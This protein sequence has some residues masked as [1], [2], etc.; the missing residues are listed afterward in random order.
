MSLAD[1][2][3]YIG[4][5]LALIGAGFG[6]SRAYDQYLGKPKTQK[7]SLAEPRELLRRVNI[8]FAK[9]ELESIDIIGYSVHSIYDPLHPLIDFAIRKG[10]QVRF[11]MLDPGSSALR[12][13]VSLEHGVTNL[14]AASF[15]ARSQRS[16]KKTA[17]RIE[18]N[19]ETLKY[20]ANLSEVHC[21]IRVYDAM[22]VYRA[23]LTNVGSTASS[24]LD[25]LQK[26]SRDFRMTD[27]AKK[28]E[29]NEMEER[30]ARNWFDYVWRYRSRPFKT[31][32]IL[33]DLYD[34]LIRINSQKRSDHE[35]WMSEQIGIDIH[36]FKTTWESTTKAS[37]TGDIGSTNNRFEVILE[38]CGKKREPEL[39]ARLAAAEHAFLMKNATLAPIPTR[40]LQ[41][42]RARGYKIGLV[43][44]CSPSVA[45]AISGTPLMSL[46]DSQIFSFSVASVKPESDIYE[47]ALNSIDCA[48][49]NCIF[50]GD[51]NNS[52]LEGASRVGLR[53]IRCT[54][55]VD[56]GVGGGDTVAASF[57][58]LASQIDREALWQ[59]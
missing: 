44:N 51:G 53:T 9:R 42:L 7:I 16:I 43:T 12:D 38:K 57:N 48:A 31:R 34:T 40:L 58:E 11:L 24:Y 18:D 22:P 37:N 59:F 3:T 29:F 55:Y 2:A 36:A 26:P 10:A 25:D 33:F 54:W 28:A 39:A 50:V 46:T 14:D 41:E 45:Y 17:E 27:P 6:A 20:Q 1:L 19:I 4:T 13:K 23:V 30:R 15:L 49:E 21:A 32:A 5:A 35:A 47:I 56:H 52:E 8:E